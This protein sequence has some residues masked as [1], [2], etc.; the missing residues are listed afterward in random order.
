MGSTLTY[1]TTGAN[2]PIEGSH[3]VT[4]PN[5]TLPLTNVYVYVDL[6][7]NV[8]WSD[9]VPDPA[10]VFGGSEEPAAPEPE[11]ESDET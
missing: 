11:P 1:R 10:Q 3:Y 2:C 6:N 8:V 9:S 7:C 5:D 4:L